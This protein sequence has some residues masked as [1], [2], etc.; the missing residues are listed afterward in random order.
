MGPLAS[1]L[2]AHLTGKGCAFFL[3]R[4]AFAKLTNGHFKKYFDMHQSYVRS[5]RSIKLSPAISNLDVSRLEKFPYDTVVGR[6]T[7]ELATSRTLADGKTSAPCDVV[8]GS[9]DKQVYLL[10][11]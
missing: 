6:T 10:V 2:S 5:L 8:H 9:S 4:L 1:A 11:P 3:P 7:R